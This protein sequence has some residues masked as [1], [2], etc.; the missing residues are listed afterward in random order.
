MVEFSFCLSLSRVLYADHI[1]RLWEIVHCY[2][3]EGIISEYK[4]SDE[5]KMTESQFVSSISYPWPDHPQTKYEEL[6]GDD[7]GEETAEM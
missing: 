5:K 2:L 1:C 6:F 4:Y 3:C 7:I